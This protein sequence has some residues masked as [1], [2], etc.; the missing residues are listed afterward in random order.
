VNVDATVIAE[1][2]ASRR[3][4][5]TC[6]RRSRGRSASTRAGLGEGD[7]N[8]RWARS[9]VRRESRPSRRAR[10]GDGT[11][12]VV[13][14]LGGVSPSASVAPQRR[15]V[16]SRSRAGPSGDAARHGHGPRPALAGGGD[17]A[18]VEETGTAAARPSRVR[19]S[20]GRRRF[21]GPA[22]RGR[23]VRRAP[24]GDGEDGTVQGWLDGRLPYTGS[25]P[26]PPGSRWTS[27]GRSASS[28]HRGAHARWLELR[29]RAGRRAAALAPSTTG[30]SPAGGFPSSS[31]RTPWAPPWHPHRAREAALRPRCSTPR[32]TTSGPGRGVHPGRG[33]DR[34]RAEGAR[35]PWWRS[36][37]GRV[38]RLQAEVTTGASRYE[39]PAAIPTPRRA[40]S[41]ISPRGVPRD[42]L[43]RSRARRFPPEPRRR[44]LLSGNQHRPGSHRASLVRWP[45]ARPG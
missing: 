2:R 1:A 33:A 42:P 38:L 44:G 26:S 40:R 15:G 11:V 25:G 6:A 10:G 32:G 13:V 3:T 45:P 41:R 4:C 24:R 35:S 7:D 34:H 19:W 29:L 43:R 17:R 27:R 16:G 28:A 23:R 36:S 9:V 8:E 39:A 12:K 30:R 5:R 21:S 22:R 18:R 20:R 37:R 14:L 31:S